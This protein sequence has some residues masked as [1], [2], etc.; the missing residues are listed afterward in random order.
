[1]SAPVFRAMTTLSAIPAVFHPDRLSQADPRY[2]LDANDLA[3]VGAKG[4]VGK[5]LDFTVQ[6]CPPRHPGG[7][8]DPKSEMQ[9]GP[10][11]VIWSILMG[12]MS[13][14]SLPI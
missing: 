10:D 2:V 11:S 6:L 9:A 7:V 1:M 4:R 14:Q 3:L 12:C 13:C 5:R 8:L